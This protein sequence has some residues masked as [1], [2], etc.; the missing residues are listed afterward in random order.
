MEGDAEIIQKNMKTQTETLDDIVKDPVRLFDVIN[1]RMWGE[2]P[3]NHRVVKLL[4][5]IRAA[6]ASESDK[7]EQYNRIV[8]YM[9]FSLGN[10]PINSDEGR[11]LKEVFTKI[12]PFWYQKEA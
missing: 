12:F 5:E 2:L 4:K 11:Y 8:S 6:I 1:E 7:R 10:T 9:I 3:P